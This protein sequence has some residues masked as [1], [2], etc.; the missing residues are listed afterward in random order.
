MGFL[1]GLSMGDVWNS[2]G[3]NGASR[4][5]SQQGQCIKRSQ[6]LDWQVTAVLPQAQV[7]A[8]SWTW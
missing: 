6:G 7:P 4:Y 1:L 2:R 3:Q 5:L 8:P